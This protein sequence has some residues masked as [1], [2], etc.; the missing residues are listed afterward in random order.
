MY[1][2]RLCMYE[3][4]ICMLFCSSSQLLHSGLKHREKIQFMELLSLL[5]DKSKYNWLDHLVPYNTF[6]LNKKA[7]Y[8]RN[9]IGKKY[10]STSAQHHR[11]KE[12]DIQNWNYFLLTM[13]VYG[14]KFSEWMKK[15][16][17]YYILNS[18]SPLKCYDKNTV[19]RNHHYVQTNR[20]KI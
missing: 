12:Y 7:I 3:D 15:L 9:W 14:D 16:L 4:K 20:S 5:W 1:R 13:V 2:Y 17:D 18:F 11:T 8:N 19:T 6:T 10:C